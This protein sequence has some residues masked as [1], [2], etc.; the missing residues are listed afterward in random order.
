MHFQKTAKEFSFRDENAI[1]ITVFILRLSQIFVNSTFKKHNA[2]F[3]GDSDFFP[4]PQ[5]K[6]F[7]VFLNRLTEIT[8]NGL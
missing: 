6:K 4:N 1:F 7:M 3:W 5:I 2:C 8:N